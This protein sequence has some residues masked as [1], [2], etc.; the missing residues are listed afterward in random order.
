MYRKT[1]TAEAESA[2]RYIVVD[3]LQ[4]TA[5][6]RRLQLDVKVVKA[7]EKL[8][9]PNNP[10]MLAVGELRPHVARG[11]NTALTLDWDEGNN[12]LAAIV[13]TSASS[14]CVGRQVCFKLQKHKA[15]D[16][17][18]PLSPLYEPLSY[19]LWYPTGGRGWS[20]DLNTTP[21]GIQISH[22]HPFTGH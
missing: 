5:T 15:Y 11:S 10:Y 13:D 22:G 21:H 14:D 2:V 18:P 19:P 1:W 7:L 20:Q 8:I 3:P 16:Y 6:A 17:L 12:E 9:L 4:R